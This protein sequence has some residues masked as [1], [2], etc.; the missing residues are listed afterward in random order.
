[1]PFVA[2]TMFS[3]LASTGPSRYFAVR[4]TSQVTSGSSAGATLVSASSRVEQS[5]LSNW[6]WRAGVIHAG[7]LP[8]VGSAVGVDS[9]SSA[10]SVGSGVS[11]GSTD[12]VVAASA[13]RTARSSSFADDSMRLRVWSSSSPGMRTTTF[14]PSVLISA[15]ATP[16]ASTRCRMID[17]A[18]SSCSCETD[19]PVSTL[20][21]RMI[22]VPPSRSRASFGVHEP[23]PQITPAALIANR[24][25]MMTPSQV[26]DRQALRTGVGR[27]DRLDGAATGSAFSA[28][29]RATARGPSLGVGEP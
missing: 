29:A 25:T 28:G 8:S 26:S 3:P 27:D 19:W 18:W 7:S 9:S 11:V 6:S 2:S 24:P 22:C 16:D 20:G 17:T 1:M 13:S 21:S 5:K 14:D 4:L 12:C 15:S 23:P 10:G